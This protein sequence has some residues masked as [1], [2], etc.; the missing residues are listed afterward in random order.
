MIL[1][2]SRWKYETKGRRFERGNLWK[3]LGVSDKEKEKILIGSRVWVE[4]IHEK[5]LKVIKLVFI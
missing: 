3:F 5:D 1:V 2:K 4:K